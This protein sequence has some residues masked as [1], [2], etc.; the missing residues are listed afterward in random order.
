MKTI[1]YAWGSEEIWASTDFYAGKTISIYSEYTIPRKECSKR[2]RTIMVT[3][4]QIIL[5]TD[6]ESNGSKVVTVL[7]E[8]TNFRIFRGNSYSIKATKISDV[9]LIEVGTPLHEEF[10]ENVN[11]EETMHKICF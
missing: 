11:V 5:E 1:N 6:H 3:K 9:K 2:D 4:G 7:N 8:G 10:N